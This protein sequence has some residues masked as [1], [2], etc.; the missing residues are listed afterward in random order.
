MTMI[1]IQKIQAGQCWRSMTSPGL[2]GCQQGGTEGHGEPAGGFVEE[3][4]GLI[5]WACC[6]LLAER[7][8]G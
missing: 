6:A 2:L 1:R 7:T 8:A 3:T 5:R 4:A